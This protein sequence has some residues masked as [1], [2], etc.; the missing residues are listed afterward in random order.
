MFSFGLPIILPMK[1][2]VFPSVFAII[3]ISV[4][5][6]VTSQWNAASDGVN[7]LGFPYIFYLKFEGESPDP[8][9]LRNYFSHGYLM[10]DMIAAA[11]FIC[12]VNLL[13]PLILNKNR[14]KQLPL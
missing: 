11:L 13:F 1:F 4:V 12:L 3:V 2:R 6:F 8:N 10:V 14:L 7:K 5:L 9:A